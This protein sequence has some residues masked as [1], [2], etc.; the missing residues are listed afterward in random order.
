MLPFR[1]FASHQPFSTFTLFD[2][3]TMNGYFVK[4]SKYTV[5]NHFFFQFSNTSLRSNQ[6]VSHFV[7]SH[8]P[9]KKLLFHNKLG[10]I[11]HYCLQSKCVFCLMELW[12]LRKFFFLMLLLLITYS[13]W[14]SVLIPFV[15]SVIAHCLVISFVLCLL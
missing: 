13:R 9:N 3:I 6:L 11:L 14:L 7:V 10:K 15:L 2:I 5:V 1:I 4:S 8:S 12:K